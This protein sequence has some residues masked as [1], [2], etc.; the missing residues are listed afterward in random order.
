MKNGQQNHEHRFPEYKRGTI[1]IIYARLKAATLKVNFQTGDVYSFHATQKK[2]VKLTWEYDENKDK[3]RYAFVRI[4]KCCI[5]HRKNSRGVVQKIVTWRRKKIAV[6]K[7]VWIAAYGP[8]SIPRDFQL[9]H[10][11]KDSLIN[12]LFNLELLH[13]FVHWNH[14]NG[15]GNNE[16]EW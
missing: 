12:G 3:Q 6:H 11:N 9:H 1:E 13:K 5:H 14:H 4:R 7:L 16:P 8:K 2:W 15:N 10:K